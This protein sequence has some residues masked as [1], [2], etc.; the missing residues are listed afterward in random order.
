MR[1]SWV[2]CSSARLGWIGYG[3]VEWR[4]VEC[5]A[6]RLDAALCDK[7]SFVGIN[8]GVVESWAVECGVSG[9]NVVKQGALRFGG[10]GFVV[11]E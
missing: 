4:A 1:G 5:W 9:F 8:C 2:W 6:V 3:L 11:V 10:S 7:V